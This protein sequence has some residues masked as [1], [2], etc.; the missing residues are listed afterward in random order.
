MR[1]SENA[2]NAKFVE[3]VK[4]EVRRIHLL[5]T[6]MN[7]PSGQD[8]TERVGVT[9]VQRLAKHEGEDEEDDE[10]ALTRVDDDRHPR[11]LPP[12][13]GIGEIDEVR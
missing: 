7:N 4:D 12:P 5:G 3:I 10:D 13:R 9:W 1:T 11:A 6:W 8:V 2:V